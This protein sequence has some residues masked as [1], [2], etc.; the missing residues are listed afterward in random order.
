MLEQGSVPLRIYNPVQ[1]DTITFLETSAATEGERTLQEI[2]LAPGGGNR[3]HYHTAF[4]E[5]FEVLENTLHVQ[6]GREVRILLP[7]E[8]VSAPPY[9]PHRFF[10]PT[11]RPTRFLA[12]IRPGSVGMEQALQIVYGLASDGKTTKEGVPS[13]LYHLA[14]ILS[15]SNSMM[16][17]L[18]ALLTPVLR[19][20]AARARALGIEQELIKRYCR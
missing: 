13:N 10:N 3:L 14:V 4:T 18:F 17:G 20:L 11:P 12:E 8:S 15:L 19:P 9:T 6:A 16:P 5:R 7:G 1:R 2:E